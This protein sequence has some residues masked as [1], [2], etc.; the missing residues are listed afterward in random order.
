MQSGDHDQLKLAD[1]V[2]DNIGLYL[3]RVNV[4]L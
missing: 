1:I 2:Q 4:Q 3:S